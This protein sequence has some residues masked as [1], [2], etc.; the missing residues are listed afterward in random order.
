MEEKRKSVIN[1]ILNE[2][3]PDNMLEE[4]FPKPEELIGKPLPPHK[5]IKEL[6]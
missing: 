1:E 4:F 2:L 5:L 6:F 3:R